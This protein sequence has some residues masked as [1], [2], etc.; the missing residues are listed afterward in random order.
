MKTI[1]AAALS[2]ISLAAFASSANAADLPRRSAPPAAQPYYAPAPLFTWTG[3]YAGVNAGGNWG[4]FTGGVGPLMGSANGVVAGGT[5]G[6]N[7]QMG[8]IVV[9]AEG[10][11]DIDGARGRKT[12][13]GPVVGFGKLTDELT[14]RARLGY[15]AD[16]AL[17][18]ATGGYA[19]ADLSGSLAAGGNYYTTDKWRSGYVLGAGI[20]YA[21]N[22]QISAKAEY[23]YSTFGNQNVFTPPALLTAGAHENT[24]RTGLN[25]HF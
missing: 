8:Q 17:I 1:A 21:F 6:Y 23:L 16:R 3:F 7:Y 13:P 22:N 25:Y 2:A 20:E 10:D 11:F 4:A 5:A 18:Y 12:T 19:G 9:G 14:L 24:I 15:A